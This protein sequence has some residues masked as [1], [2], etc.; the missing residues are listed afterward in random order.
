MSSLGIFKFKSESMHFLH[1][2]AM[3]DFNSQQIPSC[4]ILRYTSLGHV[5][6]HK[7]PQH[8]TFPFRVHVPRRLQ[9]PPNNVPRYPRCD[10]QL[11]PTTTI[12]DRVDSTGCRG[13]V[14]T[15]TRRAARMLMAKGQVSN[16]ARLA[17]TSPCCH[18]SATS[19]YNR[20]M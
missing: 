19:C 7:S 16:E 14:R 13:T 5:C 17:E 12:S 20:N 9:K 18:L 11:T 4:K 1:S 2:C 8:T 6:Y 15:S 10:P 3:L